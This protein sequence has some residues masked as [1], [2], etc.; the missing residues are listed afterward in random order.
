MPETWGYIKTKKDYFI[1]LAVEKTDSNRKGKILKIE[2]K[3]EYSE[4][5]IK[6]KTYTET[7]KINK[8]GFSIDQ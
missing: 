7:F 6:F 3:G 8:N 1:N 4:I 2:D 5:T